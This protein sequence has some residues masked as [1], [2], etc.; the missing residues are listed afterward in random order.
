MVVTNQGE[1]E[2]GLLGVGEAGLLGY[3]AHS[4]GDGYPDLNC[5]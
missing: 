1:G 4:N 5:L 3:A 2:G